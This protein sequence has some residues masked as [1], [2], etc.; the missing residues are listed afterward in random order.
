V[1]DAQALAAALAGDNYAPRAKLSYEVV[2]PNSPY[3]PP[4]SYPASLAAGLA[5]DP[6]AALGYDPRRVTKDLSPL[7]Q[8][9]F[10]AYP[11]GLQG[12]YGKAED[13]IYLAPNAADPVGTVLHEARHRAF[14][15]NPGFVT[16]MSEMGSYN[17]GSRTSGEET[18]TRMA[19]W[20]YGTRQAA[21]DARSYFDPR[22]GELSAKEH[23][24][25]V[26]EIIRALLRARE[27]MAR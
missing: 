22:Q 4:V 11:Q 16:E 2:P 12:V 5:G 27:G 25:N 24:N 3:A 23:D 6:I 14:T 26:S 8:S 10:D 9:L 21:D 19:D 18:L 17:D 7:P 1:A 15:R 13:R 20:L